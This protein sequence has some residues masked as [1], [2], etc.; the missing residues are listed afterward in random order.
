MM[1]KV[2]YREPR[3]ELQPQILMGAPS[4]VSEA[5][6]LLWILQ[7][8]RAEG[9]RCMPTGRLIWKRCDSRSLL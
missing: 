7:S 5:V 3:Q 9:M 4:V 1:L 6:A 2:S 8:R